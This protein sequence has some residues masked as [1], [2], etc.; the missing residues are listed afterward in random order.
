MNIRKTPLVND[1][2]YHIY[3]RSIAKYQIF[4]DADD[5][6]RILELMDIYRYSEFNHKYSKFKELEI[7]TQAAISNSLKKENN[8]LV[9]IVSY[10]I[11]PTHLH[12][13][14]KQVINEGIS[15][16]MARILNSYTKYFNAKHHRNGP[17]YESRFKNVLIK[18]DEQLLHTTRYVHLNA[19]SAGL[20]AN[21]FDWQYSSLKEYCED[22]ETGICEFSEIIDMSPKKYKKFVLDQKSYQRSLSI[23]KNILIDDYTG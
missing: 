12:L 13:I 20:I 15:K 3:T 5:Y 22:V 18:N 10:C 6:E 2:Y 19:S 23:I 16:Y 7:T 11:M 14:L 17:L 4:N 21:P 9:E 1:Q 8:I